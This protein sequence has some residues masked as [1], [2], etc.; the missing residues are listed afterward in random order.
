MN[1]I[2]IVSVAFASVFVAPVAWA[3]STGPTASQIIQALKPTSTISPTTRGIVPLSPGDQEATA[4]TPALPTTPSAMRVGGGKSA[5][6]SINLNV[7]FA[8][9][10]A[11]LTPQAKAEL[12]RLGHALTDP[13]LAAYKFK[14]VGHTDTT[15]NA[16]TN[17]ALS[18][19]RAKA[20][21]DYLQSKFNIAPSRLTALGV[22]EHDLLVPTGPNTPDRANRRVQVINIGK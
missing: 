10:S 9:G 19:A 2:G 1:R 7:D 21:D 14:L 16:T 22:G 15:G 6:P 13:T 18:N 3:Q 4:K 17:L 12:D 8:L 20:V 5:A 11:T